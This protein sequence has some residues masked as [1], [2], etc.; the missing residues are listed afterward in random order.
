MT[1]VKRTDL[2]VGW[3]HCT[4]AARRRRA[5]SGME[6]RGLVDARRRPVGAECGRPH[7]RRSGCMPAVRSG[8]CYPARCCRTVSRYGTALPGS[9]PTSTC[10]GTPIIYALLVGRDVNADD[11][12]VIRADRQLGGGSN[13]RQQSWHRAQL[14]DV[15]GE[16]PV[17]EQWRDSVPAPKYHHRPLHLPQFEHP[18]RD[19]GHAECFS[20]IISVYQPG[21]LATSRGQSR[22]ARMRH[23]FFLAPGATMRSRRSPPAASTRSTSSGIRPT[24]VW[25]TY[26]ER[27]DVLSPCG[28]VRRTSRDDRR[29]HAA[30]LRAELHARRGRRA[31]IDARSSFDTSLVQRDGAIGSVA[32]AERP[33]AVSRQ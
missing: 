14:P 11:R 29:L 21:G 6:W 17:G 2:R 9:R 31:R 32:L 10:T 15:S 1:A 16:R 20:Q 8:S 23:D 3:G 22:P 12:D 30:G 19:G 7:Q 5:H 18:A 33:G 26:H 27:A 13:D 24:P 25:M 28:S 4:R